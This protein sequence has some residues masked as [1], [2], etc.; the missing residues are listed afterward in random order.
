MDLD[1]CSAEVGH[2][3]M[4]RRLVGIARELRKL[5]AQAVRGRLLAIADAAT[6]EPLERIIS[7]YAD[8]T[9]EI[10]RSGMGLEAA[11]HDPIEEAICCEHGHRFA[12]LFGR[13]QVIRF[14]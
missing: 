7:D 5:G 14:P 4:P 12:T 2:N 13:L 10:I 6:F 1:R 3:C 9:N 8:R 11:Y